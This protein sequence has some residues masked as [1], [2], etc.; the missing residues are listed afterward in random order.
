MHITAV[1]EN[2]LGGEVRSAGGKE[3]YYH[4]GRFV[5]KLT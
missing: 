3:K 5:Q 2:V 1:H 4:Y